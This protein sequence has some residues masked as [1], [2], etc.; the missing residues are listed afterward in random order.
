MARTSTPTQSTYQTKKIRL[1]RELNTRGTTT[2]RDGDYINVFPE[3][4]R[5]RNTKEDEIILVKRDGCASFVASVGGASIRGMHFWEDQARLYIAA[6]NKIYIYNS[7]GGLQTTLTPFTTTIGE[8]GFT[9]Y[10][11]DNGTSKLVVTDGTVLGTLDSA[12]VFVAS[13][14]VDLPTPHLPYP[15]F[16]DGY[17][18]IAKAVSADLYNSNLN[19]PLLWTAGDFITS[20]MLSD[21][22]SWVSR[23]NNYLIVAGNQ[24]IEYFWDAAIATGSPLQRNDTPV[25]LKGL[26]GGMAQH[27]NSVYMIANNNTSQPD[28][29]MLEDFKMQSIGNEAIRRHLTSILP[30]N[31][32]TIKGAVVSFS[33]HNFYTIN[34]GS[35]TYAYDLESK[36]WCRWAFANQDYF[37]FSHWI[38]AETATGYKT[39]FARTGNAEIYYTSPTLYQDSN[40]TFPCVIVTHKEDFGTMRQ[41]SIS[42]LIIWADTPTTEGDLLVQWSDDDYQTFNAGLTLNLTNDRPSINRLGRFRERAFK[43]TYTQ[44]QPFRIEGIEVDI[45]MGG[46]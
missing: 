21:R 7:S 45:N 38:N 28:V 43:L 41:K 1:V 3:Q 25:K 14:S 19:D 42:R 18:F 23:L 11:Y 4:T 8:V 40:T 24:S 31:I 9:E 5:N 15:V 35:R 13:V 20:E 2:T 44:N 16:L 10:L 39:F 30:T 22:I 32:H 46:H 27:G 6:T 34:T 33:G 17:L 26:V 12:N 29:F 37:N 36:L